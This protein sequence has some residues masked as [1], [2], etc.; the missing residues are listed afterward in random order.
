MTL[1]A[2][3]SI[4]HESAVLVAFV[5]SPSPTTKNSRKGSGP[6]AP[7]PSPPRALCVDA[8]RQKCC[9]C[10]YAASMG[11]LICGK[12]GR[13]GMRQVWAGWYAASMGGLVCG[14]YGRVGEWGLRMRFSLFEMTSGCRVDGE[15]PICNMCISTS[16]LP[17][18]GAASR[19]EGTNPSPSECP[20]C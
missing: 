20:A 8:E 15:L 13:V 11:G 9:Q 1:S 16:Q 19:R 17:T 12:Y 14:K 10:R 3:Y 2:T 6:T 5:L 4:E 7:V 18:C